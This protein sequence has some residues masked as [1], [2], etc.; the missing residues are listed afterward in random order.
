RVEAGENFDG[1]AGAASGGEDAGAGDAGLD[2]EGGLE[3][4]AFDE[5]GGGE[6]NDFLRGER[7]VG[8]AERAGA[9]WRGY[10]EI[11]LDDVGAGG[12][13]DGRDDFGDTGAA[14]GGDQG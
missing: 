10:G 4:A 5:G 14:G 12:W 3:L 7:E 8:A 9:R 1:I 2:D 11:E 13:I 6:R